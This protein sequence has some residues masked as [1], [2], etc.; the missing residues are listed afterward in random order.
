M[1]KRIVS[2]RGYV[3]PDSSKAFVVV[4]KVASTSIHEVFRQQLSDWD[5]VHRLT[6]DSAEELFSII[7]DPFERYCSGVLYWW[8][9]G[10]HKEHRSW[11]DFIQHVAKGATAGGV[12][13][14]DVHTVPQVEW[15]RFTDIY[16]ALDENLSKNLSEYIGRPVEIPRR[17]IG[18]NKYLNELRAV[19][20]RDRFYDAIMKFYA[21]DLALWDAA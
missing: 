8:S 13:V 16:F 2:I 21:D 12:T 4:N 18:N 19:L 15:H 10:G 3:A 9:H 7:R 17:N 6:R 14:F 5:K 20:K 1:P 11:D